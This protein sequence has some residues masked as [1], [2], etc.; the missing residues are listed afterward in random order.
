MAS[1]VCLDRWEGWGFL[2]LVPRQICQRLFFGGCDEPSC[3]HRGTWW[4]LRPFWARNI[5]RLRSLGLRH[6]CQSS[7]RPLCRCLRSQGFRELFLW[8]G[9]LVSTGR[10][11][12]S[13]VRSNRSSCFHGLYQCQFQFLRGWIGQRGSH[14]KCRRVRSPYQSYSIQDISWWRLRKCRC[15]PRILQSLLLIACSA[16]RPKCIGALSIRHATVDLEEWVCGL[17][18]R[19]G[20]TL[21]KIWVLADRTHYGV[22]QSRQRHRCTEGV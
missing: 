11:F 2:R 17:S 13:L 4:L 5:R 18:W 21:L 19:L 16:K 7:H 3:S 10:S 9:L 6:S 12:V 8:R 14:R 20:Y 15:W 22:S 1:S